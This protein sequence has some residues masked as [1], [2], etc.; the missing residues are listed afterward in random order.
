MRF[1]EQIV[2]EIAAAKPVRAG[3]APSILFGNDLDSKS[4]QRPHVG[5]DEAAGANDVDHAPARGEGYAD[6]GDA[7][8]AGASGGVDLL[9]QRDLV[10][11]RD[12]RQRILGA[13]HRLIGARRLRGRRAFRRVEQLESRGGTADR[14]FAD[15]IGVGKCGG[16]ARD[17]AQ[18]K[19]RTG[20]IVG[21]LQP[22][23]VESERLAG[24]VLEIELAIVHAR[25]DAA[26]RA[27][28]LRRGR[29]CDRETGGGPRRSCGPAVRGSPF[30]HEAAVAIAAF[31]EPD[32]AID[33]QVNPGVAER[34]RDFARTIAG[35]L[36]R[37]NADH[38]GRR[39][40]R[41][42][43]PQLGARVGAHKLVG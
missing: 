19:A 8:I 30:K 31:D 22:P 34:G 28:S 25:R 36:P 17:P 29:G 35:D 2:V 27:V 6:L 3:L 14:G 12:Q 16:L 42:H 21:G 11:E 24:A 37:G 5:G 13:I 9:T 26:R 20:V 43:V 40:F 18:S 10:G 15:F 7:R 23:V 41:C 32:L 4:N 1:V 33:A 39:D 38:F